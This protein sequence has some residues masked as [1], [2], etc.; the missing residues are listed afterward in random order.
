MQ[1]SSVK[2]ALQ[3]YLEEKHNVVIG[4]HMAEKFEMDFT[5]PNQPE[6]RATIVVTGR[7]RVSGA[8][9]T[10]TLKFSDIYGVMKALENEGYCLTAAQ[11]YSAYFKEVMEN[12]SCPGCGRPTLFLQDNLHCEMSNYRSNPFH[13][14]SLEDKLAA[15]L[16]YINLPIDSHQAVKEG[17]SID[18]GELGSFSETEGR[19]THKG[20]KP[21]IL[22][23]IDSDDL[24]E[25]CPSEVSLFRKFEPTL[26]KTKTSLKFIY[27]QEVV[28]RSK[29]EG[30]KVFNQNSQNSKR[31]GTLFI[32]CVLSSSI[33]LSCIVLGLLEFFN[34]TQ[35]VLHH[36]WFALS[37]GSLG[38]AGANFLDLNTELKKEDGPVKFQELTT[39]PIIY[40]GT[41]A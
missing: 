38:V 37:L 18:E 14:E 19:P 7:D 11:G 30:E 40:H 39:E 36:F 10:A 2:T 33:F 22:E 8:P 16:N 29:Q 13:L 27:D 24:E 28:Q 5:L 21:T 12:L 9:T 17:E 6:E 31:R 35:I 26:A 32:S 20:K 3:S 15:V 34:V 1:F 23:M 41:C 4:D 25:I